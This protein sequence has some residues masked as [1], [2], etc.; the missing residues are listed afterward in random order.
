MWNCEVLK[1]LLFSFQQ[2]NLGK[3]KKTFAHT[4]ILATCFHSQQST[5]TCL[6]GI[7]G[8]IRGDVSVFVGSGSSERTEC[9]NQNVSIQTCISLHHS[10]VGVCS[11][12]TPGGGCVLWFILVFESFLFYRASLQLPPC[13]SC[14]MIA[15]EGKK[16]HAADGQ[17]CIKK[18]PLFP[19]LCACACVICIG[20]FLCVPA[21]RVQQCA[22]ICVCDREKGRERLEWNSCE[23]V[24]VSLGKSG[25]SRITASCVYSCGT[26]THKCEHTHNTYRQE[27]ST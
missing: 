16:M 10:K 20:V 7:L 24:S 2:L 6:E 14:F 9:S 12:D 13:F 23:T 18:M 15:D 3:K 22:Y 26:H 4:Q 8:R 21:L 19:L 1:N 27:R 25:S 17:I 5:K 11:I